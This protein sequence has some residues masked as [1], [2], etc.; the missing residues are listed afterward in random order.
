M[1][2]CCCVEVKALTI[3][4]INLGPMFLKLSSVVYTGTISG[5]PPVWPYIPC[6]PLK[7]RG[8][9]FS[10]LCIYVNDRCEY[11][12]SYCHVLVTKD[13]DWIGNRSYWTVLSCNCIQRIRTLPLIYTVALA[14]SLRLCSAWSL[15]V[16]V[17]TFGHSGMP[18]LLL[19]AH[20]VSHFLF[21]MPQT[22][23]RGDC[24]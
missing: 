19:C 15:T 14:V 18:C 24:A 4:A 11:E 20:W 6:S 17:L 21:V 3:S 13:G 8:K 23:L 9:W 7:P 2:I 5:I 16:S 12:I 22:P 10:I 1:D